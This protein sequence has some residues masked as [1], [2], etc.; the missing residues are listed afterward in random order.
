MTADAILS[1]P[2]EVIQME[3]ARLTK[4]VR[5]V[6]LLQRDELGNYRPIVLFSRGRKKKKSTAAV[7]PFEQMTRS[8]AKASDA[9]TGT[10]LRRHKKSNRKRRDGW[11]GD[12]QTNLLRASTNALKQ[13]KPARLVGL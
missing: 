1:R 3:M 8:F 2:R 6:T 9:A 11:V 10:Y 4:S 5:R 13:I 12:A 7:K